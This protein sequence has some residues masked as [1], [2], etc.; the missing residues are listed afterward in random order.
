MSLTQMA[1]ANGCGRRLFSP[2]KW[3]PG[4]WHL[5]VRVAAPALTTLVSAFVVGPDFKI[6]AAPAVASATPGH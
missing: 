5:P 2:G 1:G 6:P 3:H 4:K